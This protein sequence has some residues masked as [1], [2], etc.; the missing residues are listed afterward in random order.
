MWRGSDALEQLDKCKKNLQLSDD[1]I[2]SMSSSLSSMDELEDEG[3]TSF[4]YIEASYIGN[5]IQKGI[6]TSCYRSR[7]GY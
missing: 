1:Y 4:L 5:K 2:I 7:V 6:I 3:K